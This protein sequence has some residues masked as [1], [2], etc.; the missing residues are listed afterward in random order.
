[1]K[2]LTSLPV[3]VSETDLAPLSTSQDCNG[4]KACFL[5]MPAS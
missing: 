5:A 2:S 1:M 3:F 4:G